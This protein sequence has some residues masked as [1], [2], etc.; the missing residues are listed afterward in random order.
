MTVE[1]QTGIYFDDLSKVR[2]LEPEIAQQTQELKTEC[3][4]FVDSKYLVLLKD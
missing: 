2:V 4:D 1:Q 3:K